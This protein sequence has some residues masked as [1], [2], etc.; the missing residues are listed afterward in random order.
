MDADVKDG[1]TFSL[2]SQLGAR[3]TFASKSVPSCRL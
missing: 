1:G 3:P 2:F